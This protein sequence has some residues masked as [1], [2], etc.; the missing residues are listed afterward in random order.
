MTQGAGAGGREIM[1]GTEGAEDDEFGVMENPNGEGRGHGS[2]M[3]FV[4]LYICKGEGR[5]H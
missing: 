5:G 2:H 1:C 4:A 3:W